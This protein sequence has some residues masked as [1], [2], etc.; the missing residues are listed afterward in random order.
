MSSS[1]E[2]QCTPTEIREVANNTIGQLLPTEKFQS[3]TLWKTYS[4]LRT[5][6]NIKHN[7]NISK[8]LKLKSFL[9][10]KSVGFR[11]KKSKV[12]SAQE[13]NTFIK[14]A[15][16]E[17]HL[18][19][20][21]AL[22]V[23]IMGACRKNELYQMK[24]NDIEDLGHFILV[25]I[26]D[27]KTNVSRNFTITGEYCQIFKKYVALRPPNVDRD[28]LFLNYQKGKCT[29]QVFGVNKFST[30]AKNVAIYLNL[31]DPEKY[32]GHCLRRTSGTMLVDSGGDI[33]E[34]KRHGGWKSTEV[35][36]GYIENTVQNKLKVSKKI[37]RHIESSVEVSVSEP[38]QNI[39]LEMPSTSAAPPFSALSN[40]NNKPLG[41]LDAKTMPSISFENCS[42]IT[43]NLFANEK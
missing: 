42:N 24:I 28:N 1:E 16:N 30:I 40:S 22:I 41:H 20:K 10:R 25:S 34:L 26:P 19:T 8:Y 31:K 7:I 14:E 32:T 17:I 21:A 11:A 13:V 37:M 6:L 9:K 18:G 3:S 33:T 39:E 12:L 2:I 36:E 27:S 38:Q 35:A 43:I 4:M 5:T 29:K 15:P 23:G